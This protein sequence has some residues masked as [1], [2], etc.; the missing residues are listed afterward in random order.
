MTSV[1]LETGRVGGLAC[2]RKRMAYAYAQAHGMRQR[3]VTPAR[4]EA[5]IP[6]MA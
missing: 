2:F 1:A 5:P 3:I 4:L 6:S